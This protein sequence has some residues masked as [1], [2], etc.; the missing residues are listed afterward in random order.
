MD[1]S[2]LPGQ[3]NGLAEC[4]PAR[5]CVLLCAGRRAPHGRRRSSHAPLP[6]RRTGAARRWRD[7]V[8][9]DERV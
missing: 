8:S 1:V 9:V 3:A 4:R 6:C 5:C 2:Q 7:L